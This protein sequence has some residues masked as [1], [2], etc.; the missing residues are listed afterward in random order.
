MRGR[1]RPAGAGDQRRPLRHLITDYW[2]VVGS[3]VVEASGDAEGSAAAGL[4]MSGVAG[5]A[6]AEAAGAAGLVAS[7]MAGAAW[8][9]ATVQPTTT[10]EPSWRMPGSGTAR[11]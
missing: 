4:A 10:S 5:S 7:E 9:S 1:E 6:T 2:G 11:T 3:G 8:Y